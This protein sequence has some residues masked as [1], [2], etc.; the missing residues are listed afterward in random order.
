MV[1]VQDGQ[2]DVTRV[3][4]TASRRVGSAVARNRAKRIL[5]EAS[6]RVDWTEPIDVV[7]V[8]RAECAVA[9]ADE[10]V[11]ELEQLGGDLGVVRSSQ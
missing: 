4:V 11:A 8:A 3:A 9:R 2:A 1:H 10:V 6:R 7:L 5:R